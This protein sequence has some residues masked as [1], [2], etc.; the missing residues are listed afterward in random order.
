MCSKYNIIKEKF[1]SIP[2]K[3]KWPV[4]IIGSILLLGL[5]GYGFILFGGKLVVD[6]EDL[7][8]DAATTIETQ[9]GEVIAKVY[10]ENRNPLSI[11]Q[12][13]EYVKNAFI[14]IEDRRFYEHAGVDL[15]SVIRAVL[16]D[17]IAMEKVEGAST[18]TQQ[19]AKNLFLYNDKTWMR[20]TKEVMAAIYFERHFSKEKILELYLNK[21]YFGHGVYGIEAASQLFYSKPASKLSLAEGALLAGLAKAPN[22]YSPINYP[23]K[24]LKRRNTVL[25][26]MDRAGMLSTE[27]RLEEA[28]KTLGLDVREDDPK[29]WADSYVD[30]VMKEAADKYK[31]SID[32]L[33]RGGYRIVANMDE[34]AQ[35]IAYRQ[36]Q[37]DEYFPGNTEGVEGAFMMMD[38]AS[39][40][41]MASLGGRNYQIGE[42]NRATVKRQPGSAMKPLAVYGPAM[43]LGDFGPYSL[44]P[45]EKIAFD[46]YTAQNYDDTYD[47]A[48]TVY[49][50]LIKSKNAPAVWLLDQIGI[51][52]AKDYLEKMNI[53]I[54]DDG[55]AIALGGLTTGVTPLDMVQGYRT[56]VHGGEF[57][58]A[59]AIDKIYNPAGEVIFQAKPRAAEVFSP[60][61]AWNMTA[62]LANA[63][64][65][66]TGNIGD[67]KK[68]LAGKTGSTEHP[69]VQGKFKDIWFAGITPDYVTALWMGY[70][71]SD[72][73]HFLTAGSEKPTKLTKAILTELDRRDSL[74]AT[75]KKPENV[76]AVPK[77][78]EM[79]EVTK[80]EG[81]FSFG[82]FSLVQ[83]KLSWSEAVDDR[84]VY[85]IYRK[86]AGIDERVAE[87]KDGNVYVLKSLSIF[88]EYIYYVVPYNPLTKTEGARSNVVEISMI[89]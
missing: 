41:I 29:P 31:L 76:A 65:A 33:K 22:G 72:A 71:Q 52:Y 2:G 61:V 35:Q 89:K 60:Q 75:F 24:A 63:V 69:F 46:G 40:R 15:T 30:L 64:T 9:D 50:A 27:Q 81:K 25:K 16:K 10:Y 55:L 77:P 54:P 47:G 70:D 34:V 45:D 4:F 18:I 87:V 82:G 39:G 85:R 26:A 51:R 3:I 36:F 12:V 32:A 1:S 53:N 23:E 74:A 58:E 68:A 7:I 13:P 49:D 86:K 5:I 20:K 59:H 67:Y 17:I 73:D 8:L 21:I 44:I 84:V 57:V 19:V 38:Q 56:F 48:V 79:P 11:N 28:G 42:L 83:G 37:K 66:G 62:I 88:R 14:A 43:M 78:I 6:E 80:L